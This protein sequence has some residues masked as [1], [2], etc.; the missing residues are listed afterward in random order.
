MRQ[1]QCKKSAAASLKNRLGCYLG[2][3]RKGRSLLITDRGVAVAKLT[4]VDS[5]D[6]PEESLMDVWRKL[7]ADGKLRLAKRPLGKFRAVTSRIR[8]DHRGS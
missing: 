6:L 2:E 7:E 3:V 4:P 8:N 5:S 1:L